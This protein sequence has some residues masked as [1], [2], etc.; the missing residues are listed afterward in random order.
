MG[1]PTFDLRWSNMDVRLCGTVQGTTIDLRRRLASM[2]S[3]ARRTTVGETETGVGR[4]YRRL[5]TDV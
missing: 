3:R 2:D 4:L 1:G 5:V